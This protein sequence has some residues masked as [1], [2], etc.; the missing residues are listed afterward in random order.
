MEYL[1]SFE[2]SCLL[3]KL[4]YGIIVVVTL[5]SS[6]VFN[7]KVFLDSDSISTGGKML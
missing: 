2:D 6:L 5:V 4:T 3:N 1:S 7:L